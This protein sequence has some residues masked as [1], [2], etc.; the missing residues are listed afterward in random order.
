MMHARTLDAAVRK[1]ISIGAAALGRPGAMRIND[2]RA[3][4]GTPS[5]K[6]NYGVHGSSRVDGNASLIN[7]RAV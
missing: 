5:I 3:V 1:S 7:R 4:L 2:N 6:I